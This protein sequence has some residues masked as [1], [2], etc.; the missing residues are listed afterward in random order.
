VTGFNC[1]LL[2]NIFRISSDW[3]PWRRRLLSKR[4]RSLY[5][6]RWNSSY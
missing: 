6:R 3:D 5:F 4:K 2:F 1:D